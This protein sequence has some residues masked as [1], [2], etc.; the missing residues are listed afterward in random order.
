MLIYY[1]YLLKIAI[2]RQKSDTLDSVNNI[3]LDF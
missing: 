3:D 1:N 2:F